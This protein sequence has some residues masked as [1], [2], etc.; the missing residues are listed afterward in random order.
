[1]DILNVM[2]TFMLT[3]NK[4]M[5]SQQE[6]C[7]LCGKQHHHMSTPAQ[8]RNKNAQELATTLDI[9]NDERVCQPC[10]QDISKLLSSSSYIPSWEKTSDAKR[11]LIECVNKPPVI[12]SKTLH[13]I[14]AKNVLEGNK[15]KLMEPFPQCI[16]LCKEH[17]NMVYKEAFPMQT[18]CVTCGVS[19]KKSNS[20]TCTL[21]KVVEEHLKAGTG[22]EG[23]IRENDK[24]CY[25]CYRSHLVIIQKKNSN[26]SDL[27]SIIKGLQPPSTA[28]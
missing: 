21:P 4:G 24:V 7:K 19:L 12:T 1:M 20:K 18:N 3:M 15:L 14:V 22:F 23:N 26:D 25:S 11:C 16:S 5:E 28:N 10:R 2:T 9:A 17:Y 13:I 6:L 8:W 27:E